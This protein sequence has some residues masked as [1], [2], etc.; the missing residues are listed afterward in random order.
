[1]A[2]LQVK[3]QDLVVATH[4][5]SIWIL[6]DLTPLHQ[7]A[8]GV[9]ESPAI[10]FTPGL[11]Y[12]LQR[13]GRGGDRAMEN[14][15]NGALIR[16]YLAEGPDDDVEV[17]LTFL[18]ADGGEVRRFSRKP[19]NEDDP[20]APT[21]AGMN[22]FEWDMTYPG[23]ELPEKVINYM[24][25]TGGPTVIPGEYRVK[26][27]VGDWSRTEPLTIRKDPRLPQVTEAQLR[28][29]MELGFLIQDRMRET[30]TAIETIQSIREQARSVAEWAE[31]GGFGEELTT[32][33]DPMVAH[34]ELIEMEL[35][36]TKAESGQDM[37]NFPPQLANHFGYL[38]GMLA[39][40][41]GPPT[42]GER[43]RLRELEEE[44]AQLRG[45]LQ[46]VLDGDLVAFNAKV[47][48]LGVA[49][50][51]VPKSGGDLR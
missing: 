36:Q 3:E 50:V 38:Y 14:P 40:A 28:E 12:R 32:M 23:L 2:D 46:T 43:T 24:G 21:K 49:A 6:D 9:G 25:Y 48:E 44:L 5:R 13:A 17:T 26:L 35:F 51:V 4:G 1:V 19:E 29:Q 20:K 45:A 11:T 47:R 37:I 42:D 22:E 27:T 15:P 18:D 34:L 10:L 7:L 16:Y 39:P 33:A 31:K 8:E 30:Y 41:Y